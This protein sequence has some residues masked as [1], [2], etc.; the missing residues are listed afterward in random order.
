MKIIVNSGKNIN[1]AL[2]IP[3]GKLLFPRVIE[4]K[5]YV[6]R[7]RLSGFIIGR[8]GRGEPSPLNLIYDEEIL[9]NT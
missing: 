6:E 3:K 8:K 4:N 1:F 5:A 7:Y 2:I 9:K